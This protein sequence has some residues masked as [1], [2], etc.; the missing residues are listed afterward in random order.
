MFLRGSWPWILMLAVVTART[1]SADV[2]DA[3]VDHGA[4]LRDYYSANGLL[5]RGLH[6]LAVTEYREFLSEHGDHE[7]APTARYGL[8]VCLYRLERF[9]EAVVELTQLRALPGS[10]YAA[11]GLTIL[12]QCQLAQGRYEAAAEAFEEVVRKYAGHDLA[13]DAA[14]GAAEAFYSGGRYDE[15]IQACRTLVSRWS[16]SPLRERAEFFWGVAALAQQ[17]YAG[18]AERF[19]GILREFPKGPFADQAA[20]LLAQCYHH[21]NLIERAIRQY[22]GVL[23]RAGTKFVPDA[24]LGLGV[25]AIPQGHPLEAGKLFD[26]LLEEYPESELAP[27][28]RFHR[29]RAWFE[30]GELDRALAVLQQC[31]EE[32]AGAALEDDAVYWLAK[33]RLRQEHFSD[34]AARLAVA[35]EK[36]PESELGA[37]MHYDRAVALLRAGQS[38]A[39]IETLSEFR[40]RF[41]DHNLAGDALHLLAT[42]EHER[43]GYERSGVHCRSFL[44]SYPSHELAA[45]VVFLSA[46]NHFLSAEYAEAA[47]GYRRFLAEYPD[48]VQA[49]EARYRLGCASYR[50]GRLEEAEPLLADVVK[51]A[52]GNELFR[53]ALLALGDIHF[54]RSEW[55]RAELFLSEYLSPGLEAPSADDALLKLG[56]ALQRQGKHAEALG[57]Y[58][59]LIERYD[60]SPHKM[61]AAFERG[62][63]LLALERL[64]EAAEAFEH[65]L[66]EGGESRFK[67]YALNHL[68]AMAMR[69]EDF[70]G[71]ARLYERVAGGNSGSIDEGESLFNRG[72]A[73]LAAGQFKDAE[74]AFATLLDQHPTHPRVAP[75]G[76]Q[77]AIA[78]SR[79]DR[80]D[81]ALDT[82]RRVEREFARDLSPPLRAGVQYEKAWG[83]RKV[84]RTD[85]AAR[86]YRGL[87]EDGLNGDVQTHALLDLAVIEAEAKRYESAAKL[88]WRLRQTASDASRQ[89]SRDVQEQGTYQLAV[90]EFELGRYSESAELFEEFIT[91]YSASPLLAS[92][93][94]FCGEALQRLGKTERAVVHLARVV[95]RFPSD[96]VYGPGLLRMGECLTG[97][98]RWPRAEQVFT[99]YLDRF[100]DTD[101]WFQARFGQGWAREN[102][103]RYDEAVQAYREV[104]AR[105]RGPTAARAQFQI[106]ECLFAKKQYEDAARE[107][108]KVDILYAYP[109]WS[110]AALYEAGKCFEKLVK[111]VEARAQFKAVVE[112]FEGTRWA[113]M[114]AKRLGELPAGSLPGR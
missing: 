32:Q 42:A 76:A 82:I 45:A 43:G 41:P 77:L 109:E 54:Q 51:D 96:P 65:V 111:P 66:A 98:Q 52:P 71:A 47:E 93:S 24:L 17:D 20:L 78:L 89:V 39:A 70:A 4:A 2:A 94:F 8:A 40:Q 56:L 102:Q 48:D 29:G 22:Q 14:A 91:L 101:Q 19:D 46:E 90:C 9:E 67:P 86:T 15:A 73:L 113:E 85:E 80:Y 114:A 38:E 11:E 103:Q 92:A 58:D 63:V 99:E 62:Q 16:S 95:E 83:L 49:G 108:L 10:P 35:L 106:G 31:A 81:D 6:E 112:K 61:Q 100:G 44:E 27:T 97:L 74:G 13:D 75:A 69:R 55:K 79:Q 12:G 104:V 68:G 87:L 25:L 30:Q 37:E 28:A 60:E 57:V 110:A 33:C 3:G 1:A 72:Q 53:F 18:A 5:N 59:R 21:Q 26:Q 107:L 50:L 7:K 34:A 84:G 23:K 105:H 88:L 64:D 36:F